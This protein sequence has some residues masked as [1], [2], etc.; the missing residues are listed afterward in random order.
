MEISKN[1]YLDNLIKE[2]I[3]SYLPK[4]RFKEGVF[5]SPM[6]FYDY[7]INDMLVENYEFNI[8]KKTKN[9]IYLII[10]FQPEDDE[11]KLKKKIKKDDEGEYI[12]FN[13]CKERESLIYLNTCIFFNSA[14]FRPKYL[15]NNIKDLNFVEPN[16]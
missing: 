5:Y 3:F 15:K 14:F 16:K 10:K 8:I 9:Y 6:N 4:N 7:E 13:D 12:T 11:I 2:N 1:I